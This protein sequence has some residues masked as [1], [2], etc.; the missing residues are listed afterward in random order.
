L[1]S[2]VAFVTG[3]EDPTKPQSSIRWEHLATGVDT[4][5]FFMGVSHIGEI[6]ERLIEHGRD[7]A[8][9]VAV[10]RWGTYAHQ[11]TYVSDLA[12]IAALVKRERVKSP[13]IIV[14]GEVVRLRERLR[15]LTEFKDVQ[16]ADYARPNPFFEAL[17]S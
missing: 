1:S 12:N 8:T 6:A 5:V 2:S 9:P 14:V 16:I 13:A 4:L 11:E 3:H 7:A 10:V 15:W 17:A